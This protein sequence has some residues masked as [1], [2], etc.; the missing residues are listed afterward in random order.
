MAVK[1][2][3]S[4]PVLLIVLAVLVIIVTVETVQVYSKLNAKKNEEARLLEEL[5]ADQQ[6]NDALKSDLDKA[7]DEEFIK[8]LARELLGLAEDGERIFYDVND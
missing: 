4:S 1:K 7:D 5:Q 2:K 8:S 6:A 3:R